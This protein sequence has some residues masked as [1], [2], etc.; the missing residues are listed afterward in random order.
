MRCVRT[1]LHIILNVMQNSKEAF[2]KNAIEL[3]IIKIIGRNKGDKIIIDI[4]D[5]AGGIPQ[6]ILPKIFDE[7]YTTKDKSEGNGLGLYLTKFILEEHMKGSVEARNIDNGT[8][9]RI[10]L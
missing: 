4:I 10:I 8:M 1:L 6:N 2:E 3:R 9:F 5:N 7:D